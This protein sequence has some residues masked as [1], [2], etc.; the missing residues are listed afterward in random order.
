MNSVSVVISTWNRAGMIEKAI[1]SALSQTHP[2]MEVLVCD[3][4]STDDTE[5]VVRSMNDSRVVWLPGIRSGLPAV[6]RNRGLRNSKG[7]WIAFLDDDDEWLPDKIEKQLICIEKSECLASCSNALRLA[8]NGDSGIYLYY[9]KSKIC[10]Y[11]LLQTNLI[12]CSSC[13]FHRSLIKVIEGFPESENMKALEDYALWLRI[14]TYT[15]FAFLN[16]ALIVYK[17]NPTESI[18]CKSEDVTYQYDKIISNYLWWFRHKQTSTK[19]RYSTFFKYFA[20][21]VLYARNKFRMLL[22]V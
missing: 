15:D 13:I 21:L 4:G 22:L 19:E 6:P 20:S 3:D 10:F 7:E 5:E 17:D 9:D 12:I 14:S 1:N 2:P 16:E 18:R 8:P 11:D